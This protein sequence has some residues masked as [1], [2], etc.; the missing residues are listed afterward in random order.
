[1]RIALQFIKEM[2]DGMR[3]LI[4]ADFNHEFAMQSRKEG[5]SIPTNFTYELGDYIDETMNDVCIS[6]VVFSVK[7][8]N[9]NVCE[10]K[11]RGVWSSLYPG[12]EQ[13]LQLLI[14]EYPEDDIGTLMRQIYCAY[15]NVWEYL[16]LCTDLANLA[17]RAKEKSALESLRKMSYLFVMDSGCGFSTLLASFS[18]FF[19]RIGI[20]EDGANVTYEYIIGAETKDGKN[21]AD[22]IFDAIFEEEKACVFAIDFSYFLDSSKQDEMR[23]FLQRIKRFQGHHIFMF[24][25]PYV[26]ESV[27]KKM[28]KAIMDITLLK[29]VKVPP[30]NDN[31]ARE[32]IF[33]NLISKGFPVVFDA[34]DAIMERV[35]R[36][37]QDGR[38][39]GFCTLNKIMDDIIWKKLMYD[40]KAQAAGAECLEDT[41]S[42]EVVSDY[43]GLSA[44]K[45]DGFDELS[46]LIGMEEISDRI[47]EIVAQVKLAKENDRMDKPCLHMRFV[48]APGTGKTTVAR[49]LGRI[50][51]ENGLLSKGGFFEYGARSLIGEYIGQTAPKTLNICR[52]AYGS[53]LFIDEAY[54]LYDGSSEKD[55]GREALATLIAEMENHRDD[56]LVIMAG[57]TEDMSKLMEGNVGLRSRMPFMLEFKSYSREQLVAIYLRMAKKSFELE[58]GLEEMVAGYFDRISV[59]Y[60]SSKEFANARF[61]RNLFE[62]T[63]SKASLR[64]SGES[65]PQMLLKKIDFEMASAEKEFSEDL[66]HKATIGF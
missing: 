53:V 55:Y 41:V 40:A 39:Y 59:S 62:R 21:S 15:L 33:E 32:Y 13:D 26:T 11:L 24:R 65:N 14:T 49:I 42:A 9:R 57:Y 1:M 66:M 43:V 45:K 38:F 30:V 6:F 10:Q 56:F 47:R 35:Y 12:H 3:L 60:L 5:T 17:T 58:E 7:E 28:N 20:L 54:A 16:K 34:L 4:R 63:W 2:G 44:K 29:E 64:M 46:E 18:D 19:T 52:D 48:G 25:I 36:E 50:F 23:A 61:V 8:E 31:M 27:A 22:D 51:R 37:K